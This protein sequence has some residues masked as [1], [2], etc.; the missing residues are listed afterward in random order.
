[1]DDLLFALHE[2]T[3]IS[4][5]EFNTMV[6]ENVKGKRMSNAEVDLLYRVFYTNREALLE[7]GEKLVSSE[8]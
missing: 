6:H 3:N 7:A 5:A 4:R 8:R 2:K 1:M